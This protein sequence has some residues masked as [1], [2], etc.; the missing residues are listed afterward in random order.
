MFGI[1]ELDAE[2]AAREFARLE[3]QRRQIEAEQIALFDEVDRSGTHPADGHFSARA[4]MRLHAQLSGT[5]ASQR[6]RVMKA[7]RQL[8]T[9]AA[10]YGDGL[11]GTDQVRRI[12]AVWAN[13][14][15]REYVGVCEDEFLPAARKLE[16]RD[17]DLFC[18][19][20]V[21]QVDMDGAADK[22][23]RRWRR[24]DFQLEQ[25]FNGFWAATGRLMS[26]DGADF[27]ETLDRMVD[28]E[29][30]G[31]IET[32][33]AEHGDDWRSHLERT[34]P[35]LRYDAFIE[36]MRRDAMVGPDGEKLDSCT[37][38]VIDSQTYERQAALLLS[39]TFA[40][41]DPT[42]RNRFSRTIDGT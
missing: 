13:P 32:A 31:D 7:L 1:D 17:F 5:E 20:W 29:R 33:Q 25:D 8:P 18:V 19:Q 41:I 12:A 9:S 22:A 24:R 27:K 2:T 15:V 36:L 34:T 40:P 39:A 16:Y 10:C 21:S 35:Q 28:A 11:V 37:D 14:R 38:F 3:R 6:D 4:M 30:L 26:G 42:D 23:S